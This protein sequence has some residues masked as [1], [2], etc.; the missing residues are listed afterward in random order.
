[1]GRLEYIPVDADM[2]AG[3]YSY[4]FNGSALHS[5]VYYVRLQNGATQQ[6]KAMIKVK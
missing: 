6:V 5:G 1:M 4:E 3:T 2:A